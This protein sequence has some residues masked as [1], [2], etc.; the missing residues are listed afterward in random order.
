MTACGPT[1]VVEPFQAMNTS[2]MHRALARVYLLGVPL[3]GLLLSSCRILALLLFVP[4]SGFPL[5]FQICLV[6]QQV[7]LD[8]RGHPLNPSASSGATL[9]LRLL[10]L[11][12]GM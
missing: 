1:R 3:L 9:S 8:V 11:D 10:K 5:G 2:R 4:F 6:L 7:P 12:L